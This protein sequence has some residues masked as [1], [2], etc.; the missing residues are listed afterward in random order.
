MGP[1]KADTGEIIMGN[2]EMAEELNRYFGSVFTKE[3]TNNL[4]D[5]LEDRGSKGV[6]ELKEIFIRREIV[7][8]RLMGLKDDKSPG[9]DGLHP[10]VLREVALEIV[11][12]LVII[13]QCS[14][15]SGSVPVDWRI[16]NVIPLFRKERERK[17]GITDQLA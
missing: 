8:G 15:D 7:L 3:D 1:L 4:P 10:R 17:R 11:D 5:V 14:I 13:F 16:A 2:K 12:A 6:E 9:P